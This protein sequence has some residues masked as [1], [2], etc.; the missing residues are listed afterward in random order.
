MDKL[1]PEKWCP[2]CRM[3]FRLGPPARREFHLI[4][5]PTATVSFLLSA[6]REFDETA[7]Q[8]T[9]GECFTATDFVD[10]VRPSLRG[11][12]GRPFR[13]AKVAG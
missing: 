2:S 1:G 10:W 13:S 5:V 12:P 8:M 7:E 6:A 9:P 4:V 11:E 3:R